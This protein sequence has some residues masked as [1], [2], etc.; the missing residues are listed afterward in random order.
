MVALVAIGAG[1]GACLRYALTLI[2]KKLTPTWPLAT[3]VINTLGAL[4]AG[5]LT[6]ATVSA[7]AAAFLLT[8]MC[9]GFTT[10]STFMVDSVILLRNRRFA[11]FTTYYLGT[12]VLGIVSLVAGLWLGQR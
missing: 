4:A 2:G 12:V 10:F 8:G 9:G 6:G 5:A 11:S 3:M 7:A 1:I